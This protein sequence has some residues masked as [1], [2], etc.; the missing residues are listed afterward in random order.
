MLTKFAALFIKLA[1]FPVSYLQAD[2]KSRLE[3]NLNKTF[4]HLFSVLLI[5]HKVTRNL[6]S[7]G[8]MQGT[9]RTD[10][11]IITRQKSHTSRT[12]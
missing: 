2:S 7:K 5:L 8:T 12:I 9:H 3:S 1:H 4:P 10:C 11:L 6:Q